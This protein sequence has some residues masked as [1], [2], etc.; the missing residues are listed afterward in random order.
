VD[1][2]ELIV[3]VT[4][5]VVDPTVLVTVDVTEPIIDPISIENEIVIKKKKSCNVFIAL[6]IY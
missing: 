6:L 5:V 1:V 4:D 3:S 2:K